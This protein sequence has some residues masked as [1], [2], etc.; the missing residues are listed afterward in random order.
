MTRFRVLFRVFVY[1]AVENFAL[2]DIDPTPW[3]TDD[4]E[5]DFAYFCTSIGD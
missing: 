5:I 2:I 4:F 1:F 3:E